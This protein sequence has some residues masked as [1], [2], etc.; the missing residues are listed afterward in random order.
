MDRK[1]LHRRLEIL[2]SKLQNG[3]FKISSHLAHGFE[4]S[5]NK[6]RIADDGL[7]VPETVDGRI[8]STLH[9]VTYFSDRQD[10]KQRISLSEIQQAYF[11]SVEQVFGESFQLMVDANSDPLTFASWYISDEDRVAKTLDNL[12]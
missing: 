11:K 4:E 3:E 5:L 1:E 12:A 6:I 8:R 10:V 7:V 9:A 2:R